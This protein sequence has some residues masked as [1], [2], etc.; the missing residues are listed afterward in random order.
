MAKHTPLWP[1]ITIAC[2]VVVLMSLMW[3]YETVQCTDSAFSSECTST[4]PLEQKI[5][6]SA[7]GLCIM[8]WALSKIKRALRSRREN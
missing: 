7:F 2:A 6:L 4:S 1:W 8:A 3:G 5:V